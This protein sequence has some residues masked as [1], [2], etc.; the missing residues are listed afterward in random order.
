MRI[1]TQ[2]VMD[3][4]EGDCGGRCGVWDG[5]THVG[6]LAVEGRDGELEGRHGTAWWDRVLETEGSKC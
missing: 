4:L 6:F 2:S 1:S 5:R 3:D